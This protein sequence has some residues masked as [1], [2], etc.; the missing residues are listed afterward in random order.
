MLLKLVTN[1][2][3]LPSTKLPRVVINHEIVDIVYVM[4]E[5]HRA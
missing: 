4:H 1:V 3:T 2:K 5:I